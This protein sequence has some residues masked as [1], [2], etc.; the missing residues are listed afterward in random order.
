MRVLEISRNCYSLCWNR[1][2]SENVHSMISKGPGEGK[3]CSTHPISWRAAGPRQV[4]SSSGVQCTLAHAGDP[5]L[6]C[7]LCAEGWCHITL[8][9]L[10]PEM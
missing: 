2:I 6:S 4:E 8:L 9:R 1:G 10:A 7:A 5:V 3:G